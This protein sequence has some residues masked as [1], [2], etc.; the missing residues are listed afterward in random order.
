MEEASVRFPG[1]VLSISAG[2]EY[3]GGEYFSHLLGYIGPQTAEEYRIL[4][5]QGYQ[6]NELVGKA[7]VESRYETDLRGEP[8]ALFTEADA[9]GR[10]L[11]VLETTDPDPGLSLELAIDAE[12]QTFV[13][14]L[15]EATRGESPVASAVVMDANTGSV[16]ALVSIP[17]YDNNLFGDPSRS[18][19]F[20]ELLLDPRRPLL[21]HT[22]TPVGAGLD[23]QTG[24]GLSGIGVRK[25][26]TQHESSRVEFCARDQGRK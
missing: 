1:L 17:T 24:D 7:G 22:L 6:L 3:V 20:E 18:E 12:L 15:L 5:D 14:E 9:M 21:N 19:E 23:L 25:H 11:T 10:V 2:R 4:Q 26:H 8:G 16:L 13:G